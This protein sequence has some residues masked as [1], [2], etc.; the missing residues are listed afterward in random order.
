MSV[1]GEQAYTTEVAASVEQCFATITEFE[2]YPEWFAS[3]ERAR[4]RERYPDGLAKQVELFIDMTLKTIRYVLEYDYERPTGLTW[5][6]VE[7]DIESIDGSYVFEKLGAK[8]TRVTCRQSV[9]LGFWVPGPIRRLL[10]QHAL[11]QSVL[12]F[13]AAAEA[14]AASASRKRRKKPS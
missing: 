7:G 11:Q 4:V 1:S 8:R 10:E 3:I 14:A 13:K 6:S 9:V 5:Q 2:R 12:E